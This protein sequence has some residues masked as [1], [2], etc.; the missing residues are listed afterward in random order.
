MEN[1]YGQIEA[2]AMSN[3]YR[4]IGRALVLMEK[5]GIPTIWEAACVECGAAV[6]TDEWSG[7][8]PYFGSPCGAC[9]GDAGDMW[10]VSDEP[11]PAT[12]Q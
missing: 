8:V 10:R 12:Y 11:H 5:G 4:V 2:Q 1:N 6:L 9:G 3:A 7:G